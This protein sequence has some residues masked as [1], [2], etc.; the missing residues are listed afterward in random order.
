MILT[1][2]A[3]FTSFLLRNQERP[4]DDRDVRLWVQWFQLAFIIRLK[5]TEKTQHEE[6]TVEN[7]NK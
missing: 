6:L 2:G 3:Q 1:C 5:D 7:F 4:R